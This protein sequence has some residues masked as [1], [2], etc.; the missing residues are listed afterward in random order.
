MKEEL[1]AT[2]EQAGPSHTHGLR[3]KEDLEPH[4]SRREDLNQRKRRREGEAL[5]G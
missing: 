5:G 4:R 2:E 1:G 3:L